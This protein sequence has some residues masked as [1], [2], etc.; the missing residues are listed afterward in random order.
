MGFYRKFRV[1]VLSV[2]ILATLWLAGVEV[3]SATGL[4]EAH[5]PLYTK[6]ALSFRV[7]SMTKLYRVAGGE[8][9]WEI[10]YRH[11]TSADLVAA[12]NFLEPDATLYA[13]QYLVLPVEREQTYRVMPGDTLWSISQ[14]YDV[15]IDQLVALNEMSN[16]DL[17]RIG[18]IISIPGY[19]GESA[20][21]VMKEQM[22]KEQVVPVT[23][24][25]RI[26][27]LLNPIS[28]GELT[29]SYG[30]RNGG[31]HHGWDL[32]APE[33]TS[34][35][36]AAS[37]TVVLSRW[38]NRIYGRTVILEHEDG[39]RTLYAH[40]KRNFVREGEYVLRGQKIAEVG[41]SG[42]TTGPHLHLEVRYDEKTVDPGI[43]ITR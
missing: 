9:V 28:G 36:A 6:E 27:S 18:Q 17:L 34:I 11:R 22:V 40:N 31:F 5:K 4:Q 8:T 30:K 14:R 1:G 42:R 43:Y 12:M 39:L 29:S 20:V 35:R 24:R 15:E 19:E 37:G 13:G 32:A 21:P 2:V 38:Y 41:V 3:V 10:A 16:A 7:N 25:A 33:G 23:G 26:S